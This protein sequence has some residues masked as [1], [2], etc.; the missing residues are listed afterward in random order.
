MTPRFPVKKESHPP[1]SQSVIVGRTETVGL[2]KIEECG[3]DGKTLFGATGKERFGMM[4]ITAE[5]ET[6]TAGVRN[7]VD[8]E[9]AL[10]FVLAVILDVD[11]QLDAHTE[12]G[13]T[14][15]QFAEG[16]VGNTVKHRHM[17]FPSSLR[18]Q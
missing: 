11:I 5:I 9:N 2:V 8:P 3:Q 4:G 15:K 13:G 7:A 17:F 6:A 1:R 14:L 16:S 18:K 12:A 10:Q